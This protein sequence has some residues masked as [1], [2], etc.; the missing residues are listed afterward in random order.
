MAQPTARLIRP[1]VPF[2][3][4]YDPSAIQQIINDMIQNIEQ[5]KFDAIKGHDHSGAVGQG[6]VVSGGG[7][8]VF[9]NTATGLTWTSGTSTL[10]LTTGYVIPTTAEET[11]WNAL[12]GSSHPALTL[13]TPNNGLSLN[14][15]TQVLSLPI[16]ATPQLGGLSV[17]TSVGTDN[18]VA[19]GSASAVHIGMEIYNAFGQI[20]HFICSAPDDYMPGTAAGDSG[21]RF[22]F[23]HK[24]FIGSTYAPYFTVSSSGVG[25]F[26]SAPFYALEI[27]SD[28]STEQI[29]AFRNHLGATYR[30]HIYSDFATGGIRIDTYG[31]LR[32]IHLDGSEV[33]ISSQ[34]NMSAAIIP[35]IND[36]FDLGSSTKTWAYGWINTIVASN[37]GV[38]SL[39]VHN[40]LTLSLA[41]LS[42]YNT[43]GNYTKVQI[44]NTQA[45]DITYTLPLTLPGTT[46][47]LTSD[48][49]GN[50]SWGSG[51]G[52][53]YGAD[54]QIQYALS[55]A[56]HSDSAFTYNAGVMT[57][58]EWLLPDPTTPANFA[59]TFKPGVDNEI[60]FRNKALAYT[61]GYGLY[62]NGSTYANS[63]ADVLLTGSDATIEMWI[64]PDTLS[65]TH[66]MLDNRQFSFQ[67]VNGLLHIYFLIDG[68]NDHFSSAGLLTAGVWQHVAVVIT[69]TNMNFYVNGVKDSDVALTSHTFIAPGDGRL[70][71][72]TYN[73]LAFNYTGRIDEVRLSDNARYSSNF[74]PQTIN[75]ANDADTIALY[76]LDE[77]TGTTATDSGSNGYDM[78]ISG[79]YYVAGIIYESFAVTEVP[80]ISCKDGIE[81]HFGYAYGAYTNID[82]N[83]INLNSDNINLG[84]AFNGILQASAGY[85]YS[86]SSIS[87]TGLGMY[88]D[89]QMTS[90]NE[91]RFYSA[92]SYWDLYSTEASGVHKFNIALAGIPYITI[93]DDTGGHVKIP[94]ADLEINNIFRLGN[95][96]DS[97]YWTIYNDYYYSEDALTFGLN[98]TAYEQ[99]MYNPGDTTYRHR[100]LSPYVYNWNSG[101]GGYIINWISTDGYG[102]GAEYNYGDTFV[103]NANVFSV[104]SARYFSGD[105]FQWQGST[106]H[107]YETGNS[108]NV[109]VRSAYNALEVFSNSLSENI[110]RIGTDDYPYTNNVLE[111]KSQ[112]GFGGTYG[113][114]RFTDGIWNDID[115]G[116]RGVAAPT[117]TTRSYGTKIVLYNSLDTYDVDYGIGIESGYTWFS[118]PS[119]VYYQGFKWYAGTTNV[120]TLGGDG[121]LHMKDSYVAFEDNLVGPPV[122][123]GHSIGT[124]MVLYP[125]GTS[126]LADYAIGIDGYDMWFGISEA[127]SADHF[128]WYGG[129]T[130]IMDL[131]GTGLLTIQAIKVG[132][133]A[134]IDATVTYVDTLLGAKTLVFKKGILI[135]QS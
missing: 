131:D 40:N 88:G 97:S 3:V 10:S 98:G 51:G 114:I 48:S 77:N 23:Y 34:V 58:P 118:A 87:L 105:E 29:L 66:V 128:S 113:Q 86:S 91:I 57:V 132:S 102:A 70:F 78:A 2:P 4:K 95:L 119:A 33:D 92:T 24:F 82:G 130:K 117:M 56:F 65:G 120:M 63:S 25:I 17:I 133:D 21:I 38:S 71:L 42:F 134:G 101:S 15:G 68:Y 32:P 67:I 6:P 60:T 69:D 44:S 14:V 123:S 109:S 9:H 85:M 27:G 80:Y 43:L 72:S 103:W 36:A 31:N 93:D 107:F 115:F 106:I 13:G 26:N 73:G 121:V 112:N 12:V 76:H 53:A 35:T 5:T 45:V 50:L 79:M 55:G 61:P 104:T 84:T 30:G 125:L 83:T 46:G 39:T 111:I 8:F 90:G 11:A 129:V 28:G 126:T 122:L 99:R 52:S 108:Y 81:T 19:I 94:S 22:D 47:V 49:S 18:L 7:G 116:V 135:S 37:M 124:R 54:Y 1:V 75:Y 62:G 41:Y 100:V 89:I 74:T 59:R 96:T 16:T 20:T 127:T 110:L 64:K